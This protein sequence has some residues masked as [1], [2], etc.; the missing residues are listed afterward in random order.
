MHARLEIT[1]AYDGSE[2]SPEELF[3]R[4]IDRQLRDVI[5]ERVRGIIAHLGTFLCT[6]HGV[7]WKEARI[8]LTGVWTSD[9]RE[10]KEIRVTTSG[11]CCDE[12][13]RSWQ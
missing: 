10:V 5:I 6:T 4:L 9:G 7:P 13:E 12:F 1:V 3:D 11:P 2:G 8:D